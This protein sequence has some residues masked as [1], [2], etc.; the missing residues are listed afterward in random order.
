[1]CM[2]SV[3]SDVH[4]GVWAL[5]VVHGRVWAQVCMGGVGSG[6]HGECGLWCAWG[7]VG[8]V[9]HGSVGFG[10]HRSVGSGV[11]GVWRCAWSESRCGLWCECELCCEWGVWDLVCMGGVWDPTVYRSLL[12]ENEG[13]LVWDVEPPGVGKCGLLVLHGG[14]VGS[15]GM[16]IV[17]SGVHGVCELW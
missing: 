10:V 7:G 2:G 13:A 8:S 5:I 17:C 6:V 9:V 12:W 1:V 16:G 3:G 15:G 4:G 14:S 11:W